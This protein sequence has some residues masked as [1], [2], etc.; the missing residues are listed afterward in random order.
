MKEDNILATIKHSELCLEVNRLRVSH[1]RLSF[2][3]LLSSTNS[4]DFLAISSILNSKLPHQIFYH[5]EH[6]TLIIP[7]CK[8]GKDLGW[9]PDLKTYRQYCSNSCSSKYSIEKIKQQNLATFGKEWHSQTTDWKNKVVKTNLKK[10]GVE[11]YSQTL[12]WREQSEITNLTKYGVKRPAQSEAIQEK[13]KNTNLERYGVSYTLHSDAIQEKIKNTNLERYGDIS[14]MKNIAIKD[15]VKQT[16]IDRY[17]VDHPLKNRS[18]SKKCSDTRKENYYDTDTLQKI[19]DADWMFKEHK[20]GKTI[21]EIALSIG[22]SGSNLCKIFHRLNVDIIRHQSSSLERKIAEKINIPCIRNDR[23]IIPPKELDIVFTSKKLAIE[24][25]G[26]YYHSEK[27]LRSKYYH[28]DKTTKCNDNGYNLLQFWDYEINT[29]FDKVIN[30]IKSKLGFGD[31]IYARHTKVKI[32][33]SDE[34]RDFINKYH[35]QNDVSSSVNIGLYFK[36]DLVMVATFG[37]PRFSKSENTFELL[38]LCSISGFTIVGGASKLIKFF[39]KN[40]MNTNDTLISY[41][42]RRYSSGNVYVKAGF[43]LSSISPPGFFYINSSGNYAG[44]RYQFQKHLLPNKL[45]NFDASLTAFQN[46]KNNG[47]EKVWDCG[48]FVFTIKK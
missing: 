7:K 17:G 8:C 11:H 13:I 35:L 45:V 32:I 22:V 21:G 24:I 26:L 6:Q 29:K 16:C 46:M 43:S 12:E 44:S 30:I 38:R 14:P 5:V 9:H 33:Q 27:F 34:K 40:Y 18:I 42:D 37:N 31:R 1:S 23:S 4:Q 20:S 36:D 28:L 47:Y 41:C 25:N 10:Y 3:N 15:K 2:K 39:T 19:N 48:Q